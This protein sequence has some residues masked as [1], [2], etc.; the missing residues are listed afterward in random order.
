[1]E[2]E[3]M[4]PR[5]DVAALLGLSFHLAFACAPG[6]GAPPSE[7]N[8]ERKGDGKGDVSAMLGMGFRHAYPC[9]P[10]GG[11]PPIFSRH[12]HRRLTGRF[13]SSVSPVTGMRPVALAFHQTCTNRIHANVVRLFI[14]A[15]QCPQTMVEVS[16]LPMN[17]CGGCHPS[18]PV[19]YGF[20]KMER[21]WKCND[22]VKVIRHGEDDLPLPIS[23][24]FPE[25]H[26]IHD[27]TPSGGVGELVVAAG[28]AVDGHEVCFPGRI[29]PVRH[30]MGE[31][32]SAEIRHM[33]QRWRALAES[34]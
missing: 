2:C 10:G 23:T 26:R 20:S 11:A 24:L 7:V 17:L 12:L 34:A 27:C 1:M 9:A 21:V 15:L 30:V 28:V 8:E 3:R 4:M 14:G 19:C 16:I 31:L 29:N 22:A 33:A 32:G 25:N 18:L 6:G 13:I 5:G